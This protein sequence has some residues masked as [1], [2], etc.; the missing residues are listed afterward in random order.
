MGILDVGK[1]TE[2]YKNYWITIESLIGK[3]N[4]EKFFYDFLVSKDTRYIEE[5]K[6]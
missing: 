5:K 6:V 1:Q 3:E 4:I 2:I